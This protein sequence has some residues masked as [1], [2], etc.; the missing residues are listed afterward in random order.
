MRCKDM[1]GGL[2]T[3]IGLII[4][5]VVVALLGPKAYFKFKKMMLYGKYIDVLAKKKVEEWEKQLK[6]G[7]IDEQKLLEEIEKEIS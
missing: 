4:L 5:V 7:K 1:L 2:E 6:E 3:I